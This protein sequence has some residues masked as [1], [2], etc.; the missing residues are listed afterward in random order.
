MSKVKQDAK[1]LAQLRVPKQT[2]AAFAAH[3]AAKKTK[4]KK[5]ADANK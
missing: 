1:K 5:Q 3:L 2:K 4:A